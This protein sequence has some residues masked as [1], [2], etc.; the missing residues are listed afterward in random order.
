MSSNINGDD[1]LDA[2]TGLGDTNG[3]SDDAMNIFGSFTNDAA[4]DSLGGLGSSGFGDISANALGGFGMDLGSF[5][6]AGDS[7]SGVDLSSMQL[8]N[9]N[10]APLNGGITNQSIGPTDD[11]AQLMARLLGPGTQQIASQPTPAPTSISETLGINVNALNSL[12]QHSLGLSENANT[13]VPQ[14]KPT[15][16]RAGSVS[17]DEMGDIPLAQLALMPSGQP[18]S[19]TST[20]PPPEPASGVQQNMATL[21]QSQAAMQTLVNMGNPAMTPH[22]FN[23]PIGA[24]PG[25][26]LGLQ[27]ASQ[28]GGSMF[29][30]AL[31][32]PSLAG[33]GAGQPQQ[34]AMSFSVQGVGGMVAQL[35]H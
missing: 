25:S 17:S 8:I 19:A 15:D 29:T 22:G 26:M 13:A 27:Q 14:P 34:P 35:A 28:P 18:V 21:L 3:L 20:A 7:G 33:F 12:T 4:A 1:A 24:N 16:T 32:E 5:D 23:V 10:D 2:F 6:M 11:A 31:A 9:L 30:M